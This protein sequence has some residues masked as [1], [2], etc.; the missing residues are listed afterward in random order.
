M[1]NLMIPADVPQDKIATYKNNFEKATGSTGRLMLF[2][3]DQKVEHLNK[4][5]YGEGIAADDAG[6]EH[7]FKIANTAN[8]GVFATQM[9]LIA[10]YGNQYNHIPYLVKLNS[11][12]NIVPVNEKP[13]LSQLWFDVDDVVSFKNN[14]G[15]TILGIGYTIY[16]GSEYEHVMLREAAQSIHKAHQEGLIAVLWIYPKGKYI[17]EEHDQHLIAGAA[18][19]AATLGADFVKLKVPYTDGKFDVTLLHEVTKAAGNT[20]VLCEGGA[21]VEEKVFLQELYDQLHGGNTRG[22]GTGRNIHQRP[23]DEAVKMT[24]AIYAVTVKE[25][26]AEKA[27][28][29]YFG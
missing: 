16:L 13:P 2:A 6:P 12:T 19:V 1:K 8:I 29:T 23:F 27:W 14:S 26:T 21:K 15:L 17:K 7:L 4:D 18:G 3:G 28:E 10:R 24:N 5:F 25:M 22:N 9:G 11:K 20:G